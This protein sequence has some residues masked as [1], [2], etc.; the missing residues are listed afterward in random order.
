MER[1]GEDFSERSVGLIN[2]KTNSVRI[3]V[4]GIGL[5]RANFGS[6]CAS[7]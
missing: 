5:R 3:Q 6:L 2:L 7:L 1:W 4:S